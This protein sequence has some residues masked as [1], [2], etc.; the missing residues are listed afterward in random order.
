MFRMNTIVLAL[1]GS[2]AAQRAIPFARGL[3]QE[4]KSRIV[5][6]H[7]DE[8]MGTRGQTPIDAEEER[9]RAEIQTL[10]KELAADGIEASIEMGGMVSRGGEI[11]HAIA[12]I[13]EKS[14][15][16]L[17]VT[18]TRGHSE[19]AGLFV[20]SVTQRLLHVAKQPVLVVPGG[21]ESTEGEALFE[22]IVLALDGSEGSKR[23][24]PV[25]RELA[26]LGGAK[27]VI[28]HV[29][30]RTIGKGGGP[31]HPDEEEIRAEIDKVAEEL[32]NEGIEAKVRAADVMVGGPGHVIAST[33]DESGAGLIVTGTRGHTAVSGLLL[34][35]VTLRLLHIAHQPVLAVPKPR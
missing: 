13:A 4:S 15:A 5:I 33:A 8:R 27:I 12:D 34:G 17:I 6:A 35:G 18:G 23:A 30:E 19:I 10:G 25:A 16:D 32:S 9:I 20:G 26:R 24:I 11:A 31:I 22:T 28:A 2:E 29:E 14:N 21:P 3:A 7:V 1:D